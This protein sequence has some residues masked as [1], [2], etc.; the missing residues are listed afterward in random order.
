MDSIV[1][2]PAH[3]MPEAASTSEEAA[4]RLRHQS[5]NVVLD[6]LNREMDRA[7]AGSVRFAFLSG[8]LRAVRG[9]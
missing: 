1:I 7:S 9:A 8:V 2:V 6:E 5:R 4:R 3:L